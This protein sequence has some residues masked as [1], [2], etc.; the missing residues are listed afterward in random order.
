MPEHEAKPLSKD[1]ADALRAAFDQTPYNQLLGVTVEEVRRDWACLRLAYS[2]KLNQP[3]GVVH[4]GALAS[5]IDTA[6][7]LAVLSGIDK[8]P[9]KVLTLDFHLQYIGAVREEDVTVEARVR[10]RGRSIVF[11]TVDAH[12]VSGKEVAHGELSFFVELG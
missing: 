10:K 11:L 7:A 8:P 4:G 9:Q 3:H 5:V 12:T 2:D 1:V 6:A